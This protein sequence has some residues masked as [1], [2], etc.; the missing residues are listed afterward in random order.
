MLFPNSRVP[1]GL[2]RAVGR[3]GFTLIEMMVVMAMLAVLLTLAVPRYFQSLDYSKDAILL[4]NL[5]ATRDIIDT[6]Y[7]DTGRYPESLN[8][9]VERHYLRKLPYDP[10]TQSTA[11]WVIVAPEPPAQGQVYDLHSGAKGYAK[12]GRSYADL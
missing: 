7:G 9:L 5:K 6:F 1:G 8:E 10:I 4:E 3:Q 12:D 2:L 11:S